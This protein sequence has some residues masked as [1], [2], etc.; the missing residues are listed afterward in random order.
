MV[1]RV[2]QESPKHSLDFTKRLTGL[3]KRPANEI[4]HIATDPNDP[5]L[6]IRDPWV[7]MIEIDYSDDL[8]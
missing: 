1:A 4:F 2:K 7:H 8:Q 5:R 6:K 3:I